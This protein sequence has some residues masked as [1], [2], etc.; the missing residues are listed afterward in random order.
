MVTVREATASSC[1]ASS[2]ILSIV[3]ACEEPR[4][5]FLGAVTHA[6][7]RTGGAGAGGPVSGLGMF[8]LGS[9]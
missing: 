7:E 8:T 6:G 5:K 1:V 9:D 4:S 3:H 2:A